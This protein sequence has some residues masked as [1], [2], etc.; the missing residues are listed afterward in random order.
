MLNKKSTF[1]KCLFAGFCISIF[2]LSVFA[3]V[4][5]SSSGATA[6]LPRLK[7][8]VIPKSPE[9]LPDNKVIFR[10]YAPKATSVSVTGEWMKGAGASENMV[11]NDTGLWVLTTGPLKPEYY[12]YKFVINGVTVLDPNN[13]QIRRDWLGNESVLLVPGKESELYI[14]KN[15]PGGTLSK[16]WYDSPVIA[17]RR[18]MNIYTP[19]GYEKGAGKYP[20]LYLLHGGM[21]DEDTW[22]S[23]GRTCQIM[24][25]LIAQ[26]KVKPMIVIMP[27]GNPDQVAVSFDSYP[28]TL[29]PAQVAASKIASDPPLNMVNGLFE[30]SLIKDIIPFIEANYR[31]FANKGNRA[32]AG[33]SMGGG[34]TF[35]ITL[36]NPDTFS[37]IG[38]FAP[39]IFTLP[40][41]TENQMKTLGSA[42]SKLYWIGCGVDDSLA[43]NNTK[44]LLPLLK[45]NNINYFYNE[46]TGGHNWQ[47]WRIYLSEYVPMLFK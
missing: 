47:N 43:I 6:P 13:L 32:I 15:V 1:K 42:N 40:P 3:Q 30:A 14:V 39:A 12:G 38:L 8:P 5:K 19:P 27:N 46:S 29:T 33:Y 26:G 41:E 34:Q 45:K 28:F 18:R 23:M 31:V 10:L 4:T 9:V 25:N 2:S 20:V 36:D 35:Q 21:N 22:T 44:K 37:Y 17:L 11:K 24:D 7:I 16:V